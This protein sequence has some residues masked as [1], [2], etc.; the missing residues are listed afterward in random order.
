[1]ASGYVL[2]DILRQIPSSLTYLIFF[3]TPTSQCQ[4][5]PSLLVGHF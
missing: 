3:E 2:R 4:Q 5:G 1:V